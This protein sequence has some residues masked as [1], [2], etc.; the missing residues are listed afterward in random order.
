MAPFEF[1]LRFDITN[2]DPDDYVNDTDARWL[3][4]RLTRYIFLEEYEQLPPEEAL[5]IRWLG[6]HVR[7]AV[8]IH[9]DWLTGNPY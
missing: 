9:P 7:L 8:H 4:H 3:L 6:S 5:P 1:R 2:L